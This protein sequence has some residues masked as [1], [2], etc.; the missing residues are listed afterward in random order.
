MWRHVGGVS[1]SDRTKRRKTTSCPP[2]HIRLKASEL[3]RNIKGTVPF[4]HPPPSSRE[5]N[6]IR[7]PASTQPNTYCNVAGAIWIPS[8]TQ[9]GILNNAWTLARLKHVA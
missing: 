1:A 9:A 8:E 6:A 2:L 7:S 4:H 5:R 3:K